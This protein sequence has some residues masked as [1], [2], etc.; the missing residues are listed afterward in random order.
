MYRVILS[1]GNCKLLQIDAFIRPVEKYLISR[2]VPQEILEIVA[3]FCRR[4]CACELFKDK[5]IGYSGTDSLAQ[6]VQC[7]PPKA[8]SL[9]VNLVADTVPEMKQNSTKH[10]FQQN[11][12]SVIED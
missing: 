4:M 2:S 11:C 5:D 12:Q 1:E 8:S 9:L 3:K 6:W 10:F 7:V